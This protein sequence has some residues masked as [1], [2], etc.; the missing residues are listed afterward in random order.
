VRAARLPA[1][2]LACLL[3]ASACNEWAPLG[4]EPEVY[5]LDSA[6][7]I[8]R[9]WAERGGE[10]GP[11]FPG[12]SPRVDPSTYDRVFNE[13]MRSYGWVLRRKPCKPEVRTPSDTDSSGSAPPADPRS[14][15]RQ[16]PASA[17]G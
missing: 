8:C 10:R 12:R 11:V 9:S 1:P 17:G 14:D 5:P 4:P 16:S 7:R 13:C 3:F 6:L 2:L 15:A